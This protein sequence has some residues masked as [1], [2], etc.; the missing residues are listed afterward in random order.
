MNLLFLTTALASQPPVEPGTWLLDV[1]VTTEAK[2]PF[3]GR[4]RVVTRTIGVSELR[5]DGDGWRQR[6]VPC[7]IRID[8]DSPGRT[9][10][11]DAFLAG[12][13]APEYAVSFAPAGEGW[14]YTADPGVD[15][16]GFDPRVRS[17][18]PEDPRDPGVIDHEG[19]GKPG[20]TVVLEVPVF[21]RVE[22]YV[23]Q[24]GHVSYAGDVGADGT[25]AG[26]T[27]IH[28]VEQRS[29]GASQSMFAA[30]PPVVPV[31]GASS[32][33]MRPLPPG[34]TCGTLDQAL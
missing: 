17:T 10:I 20:A 31:G 26:S 19:D 13:D 34:T 2:L 32:F 15:V 3:F 22:V 24:I 23:A 29:L 30:N 16:V 1:T 5:R 18:L 33:R 25:I 27:V 11:P 21:G 6:D 12:L 9:V 8:D 7:R 14:R 28:R 4:S